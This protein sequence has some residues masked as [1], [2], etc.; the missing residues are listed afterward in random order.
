M[1]AKRQH[2]E[3]HQNHERWLLTYADLITLL[4]VFFIVMYATSRADLSRFDELAAS[5]QRAFRVPVLE[6]Q[7]PTAAHGRNGPVASQP[8]PVPAARLLQADLMR[9]SL[10]EAIRQDLTTYAER[11]GLGDRVAVQLR[12]DGVLV[13]LSGE[14]LFESGKADLLPESKELLWVV[15]SRL[16]GLPNEVRV[17]GHTDNVPVSTPYFPS[18][19]ELS[20][21]RALTV[22]HFLADEVQISPERLA[23]VGYGEQRPIASNAT[24]EGRAKNRRVELLIVD[25]D[26]ASVEVPQS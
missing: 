4:M 20:V 2:G 16:P 8:D 18:N 3:G 12:Q 25:P 24:R 10:Y 6:G 5:L 23:V 19:W 11:Y 15:A 21:A 9:Q 14:L 26:T 1:R 13:S 7:D 22:L 17:A